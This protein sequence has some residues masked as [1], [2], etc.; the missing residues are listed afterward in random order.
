[1]M[2]EMLFEK[3]G[4]E[5]RAAFPFMGERCDRVV[6]GVFHTLDKLKPAE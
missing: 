5:A 4:T 1:M 6:R 3:V 2:R